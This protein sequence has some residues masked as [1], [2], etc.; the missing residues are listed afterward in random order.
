VR[1]YRLLATWL[2]D[3]P[4]DRIW[5]VLHDARRWPSW[6]RGVADAG[7]PRRSLAWRLYAPPRGIASTCGLPLVESHRFVAKDILRPSPRIG[8]DDGG[9]RVVLPHPGGDYAW[10]ARLRRHRMNALGP[11]ARPVSVDQGWVK[12]RAA[13]GLSRH[14]GWRLLAAP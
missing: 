2:L 14:L 10:E 3:A 6:S 12:R 8:D 1:R 5:D 11:T 9:W 13:E 4:I 7:D